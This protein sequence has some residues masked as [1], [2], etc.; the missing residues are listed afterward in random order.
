MFLDYQ[1]A[2]YSIRACSHGDGGLRVGEVPCLGGVTNLSIQV[3]LHVESRFFWLG[4]VTHLRGVSHFHVNSPLIT[5]FY[6]IR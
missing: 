2:F 3:L 5:A 6:K 1:I 4:A